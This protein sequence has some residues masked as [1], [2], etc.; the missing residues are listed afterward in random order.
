MDDSKNN[1]GIDDDYTLV[2]KVVCVPGYFAPALQYVTK[3]IPT[4]ERSKSLFGK[5]K[6]ITREE[7]SVQETG[8]KIRL[9]NR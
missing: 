9:Q 2:N 5:G 6:E 8:L 7:V 3:D 4:G 1:S